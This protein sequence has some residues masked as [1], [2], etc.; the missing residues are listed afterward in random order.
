M[1]L[2]DNP[3]V[4]T[5]QEENQRLRKSNEELSV[6]NELA[7]MISA[8][9][10]TRQIMDVVVHRS[11]QAVRAEQGV[12]T[13]VEPTQPNPAKTFLRRMIIPNQQ[14]DF[15]FNHGLLRWMHLHKTPLLLHSPKT[16]PR[17][18]GIVWDDEIESL[19][20][21]PMIVKS[22]LKGVLTVYNKK[23]GEEFTDD[24]LK[25]LSIIAA[26][27]AQI[28]ENARLNEREKQLLKMQEELRLAA[29][30]QCE[31]LPKVMPVIPGYDIAGK[32]I[33]AQA[34]GGDHFDFIP[35]EPNRLAVC[36]GDVSG[37]GLP[38]SLLMANLQATLR[39]QIL[40]NLSPS[41]CIA[42]ANVLMCRCTSAE[43]FAT[44]FYG[45]LD[46]KAHL[47]AS[48]NAGHNFPLLIRK[49][50]D[51]KQLQ[52]G[53][54][55]LALLEEVPYSQE[56]VRLFEGDVL[57]VYSDGVSEA[58]NVAQQQFGEDRLTQIIQNSVGLPAAEIIETIVDAVRRFVGDATQSDDMTLV[59]I[60]RV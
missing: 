35:L 10:D 15:H 49:S 19:I 30:I 7:G 18:S 24:D 31:L 16:D 11:L 48:C 32:N 37:K 53:G 1:P 29:Q 25:L 51:V 54:L 45:V 52:T 57:V 8:S 23:H 41:E 6:L 34:V 3:V 2:T 39:A 13:S 56:S 40:S 46:Y 36:V 47:L 20:C 4:R 42:Q 14:K 58:M 26:Q 43:K 9:L 55:A 38:A 5:L 17:F 59:V 33:P 22:E 12:I 21:A 50:G 44:V 27:S 28:I 60:K